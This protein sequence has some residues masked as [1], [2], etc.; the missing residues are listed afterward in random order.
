MVEQVL[1]AIQVENFRGGRVRIDDADLSQVDVRALWQAVRG[2]GDGEFVTVRSRS[3]GDVT[4]SKRG[5][6]MLVAVDEKGE[7]ADR[8][9]IRVPIAVVD[10]L[11]A[12]GGGEIDVAAAMKALS[13]AGEGDLVTVESGNEKVRIWVDRNAAAAE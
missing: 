7:G 12:P 13:A 4:V 6:M 9:R 8:V 3:D 10:A 2:A 5:G 1:P 11:F